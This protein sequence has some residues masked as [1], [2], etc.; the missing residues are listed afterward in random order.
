MVIFDTLEEC[1]EIGVEKK[2]IVIRIFQIGN[3]AT[4]WYLL[5]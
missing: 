5:V 4:E 3:K 2:A 1:M